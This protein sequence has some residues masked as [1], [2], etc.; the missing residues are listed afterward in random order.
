MLATAMVKTAIGG[1]DPNWGRLLCAVGNAGVPISPDRIELD[2]GEVPV[3]RRGVGVLGADTE[4]RAHAVMS[5]AKY[6]ITVRLGQGKG[7][8]ECTTCD[9]S[10]EYVSINADYRS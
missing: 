9:L 6:R 3:V 4:A 2:I 10:H 1:A 5:Q 8:A 7:A